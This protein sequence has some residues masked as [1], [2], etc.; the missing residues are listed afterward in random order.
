[1][2]V[3]L[4]P[5]DQQVVVLT[6]AS[7]GIGLSTARLAAR[8]GARLVLAARNEAALRQ[9]CDELN[10]GGERRAVAVAADVAREEDVARIAET[11]VAE[12]GR[13]DTWVNNAGVSVFGETTQ[14]TIEDFRRVFDV[15]SW[16]V[17][18][19]C[20]QAV[21]HYRS[22]GDG[23]GAGGAVVNVGSLFGDRATP[24]HGPRDM[25]VGSQAKTTALA[26][27]L[28]P[29]LVD[30]YME[31][32]MWPSQMADDRPSQ[33]RETPDSPQPTA[34]LWT[35]GYGMHV[36]GSNAGWHRRRSYWVAARTHPVRTVAGTGVAA[37]G[38]L[39]SRATRR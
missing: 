1:M 33:P 25:F 13:F 5:L 29:R 35:A 31:R 7:S 36:R 32:H 18:Y 14:V 26:G 22:R 30:R 19:G 12:F 34:A 3:R 4:R 17:V 16:S 15:V 28:F 6:G 27:A 2:A 20:R 23:A 8:R 37:L 39:A 11:A 21:A 38:L 10:A 24:L 9:L